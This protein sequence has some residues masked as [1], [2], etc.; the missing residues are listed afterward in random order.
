MIV[1]VHQ[2]VIIC[3]WI[4]T[5]ITVLCSL[6]MTQI[7]FT[8]ICY[9]Q[10]VLQ[11]HFKFHLDWNSLMFCYLGSRECQMS[12]FS[13]KSWQEQVTFDEM[14]VCF[15]LDWHAWLDFCSVISLKQQSVD[16]H[17]AP[18][19]H[20][21]LI[22]SQPVFAIIPYSCVLRREAWNTNFIVFF[23]LIQ[24]GLEPTIYCTRD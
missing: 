7:K 22:L 15:V 2:T 5:Q 16:R 14:N 6:C 19:G 12:K 9:F 1:F 24:P 23:S 20:I 8:E 11:E 10:L 17:V 21:I 13:A 3:R 4:L 18:F